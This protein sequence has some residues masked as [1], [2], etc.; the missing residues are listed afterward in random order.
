MNRIEC[1]S[2]ILVVD[3][4]L[5]RRHHYGARLQTYRTDAFLSSLSIQ[6]LES[7]F[8]SV[9]PEAAAADVEAILADQSMCVGAAS[10]VERKGNRLHT[11]QVGIN[12]HS[13][14]ARS[15]TEL[16]RMGIPYVPVSHDC[17][18]LS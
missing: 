5:F 14:D 12:S 10:A 18:R 4:L 8:T 11:S 1:E 17:V 2:D 3:K 6:F 9:L 16:L 15:L 13:P 7:D